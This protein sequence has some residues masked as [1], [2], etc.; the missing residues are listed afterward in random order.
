MSKG[1]NKYLNKMRKI[2][3]GYATIAVTVGEI[4]GA[5]TIFVAIRMV[6][7][8]E[9]TK[10]HVTLSKFK[11]IIDQLSE[12]SGSHGGKYEDGCFLGCCA[13]QSGRKLPTF[14][15]C[16]MPPSGR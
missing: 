7:L 14:Q 2:C 12:I 6:I 3:S 15:R 10:L 13:V 16:L 11:S 9:E 1:C 4:E 8:V 5:Y